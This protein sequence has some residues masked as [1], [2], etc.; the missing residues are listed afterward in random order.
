MNASTPCGL[1]ESF[2]ALDHSSSKTS[3]P[4]A[5]PQDLSCDRLSARGTGCNWVVAPALPSP[6]CPF[7]EAS[8]ACSGQVVRRLAGGQPIRLV[9]LS[10][11]ADILRPDADRAR[12]VRSFGLPPSET[13]FPSGRRTQLR[14]LL[15]RRCWHGITIRLPIL[16]Y[17]E[18]DGYQLAR[19]GHD[20]DVAVLPATE[21]VKEYPPADPIGGWPTAPPG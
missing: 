11:E 19:R 5:G 17:Q 2:R 9:K 18:G 3:L 13:A 8:V 1:K 7:P 21:P 4:A 14:Q 10:Q 15:L 16:E 6:A 12:Q 20:C